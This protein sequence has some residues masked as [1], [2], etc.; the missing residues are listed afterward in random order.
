[1]RTGE[2]AVVGEARE[3]GTELKKPRRKKTLT[4]MKLKIK[5]IMDPDEKIGIVKL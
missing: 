1:M 3:T 5:L 4:K 2:V